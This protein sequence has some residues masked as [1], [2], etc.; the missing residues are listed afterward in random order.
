MKRLLLVEDDPI[1]RRA[2]GRHLARGGGW[3]VVAV[4]AVEDALRE[5]AAGGFAVVLTDLDLEPEHRGGLRVVRACWEVKV[6]VVM[7]SGD[8]R[9]VPRS[10]LPS[11]RLEKPF[12]LG[13][14]DRL[15]EDVC[16]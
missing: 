10:E 5:L 13:V 15:L 11:A 9:N 8:Y 16:E 1:L 3:T 12:E 7:M 4:H 6:P 2:L 14:L